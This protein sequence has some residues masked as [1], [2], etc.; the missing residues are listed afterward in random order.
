M[1]L[2]NKMEINNNSDN[3][4]VLSVLMI[5]DV[6]SEKNSIIQAISHNG[7][8]TDITLQTASSLAEGM[9]ILSEQDIDVVLL[10]LDLP[11]SKSLQ[12]VT[13]IRHAF[14]DIAVVILSGHSEEGI[15]TEAL[16][17]GA[18]EFLIKGEASGVMIKHT[19]RQA[20]VRN[21][22]QKKDAVVNFGW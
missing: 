5:E 15:L 11:D 6:T 8:I 22:L 2:R 7:M 4:K 18:Q 20:Y 12:S 13:K 9:K 3:D 17:L 16:M 21:K 10:D 14:P 1:K 19:I